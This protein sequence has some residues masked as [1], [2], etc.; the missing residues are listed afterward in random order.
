MTNSKLHAQVE[1]ALA[2][3]AALARALSALCRRGLCLLLAA[4]P[5]GLYAAEP[6]ARSE[7][8][9]GISAEAPVPEPAGGSRAMGTRS[10][11]GVMLGGY[12]TLQLAVPRGARNP[13]LSELEFE[14]GGAVRHGPGWRC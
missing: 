11:A 6:V 2:R 5:L 14:A 4:A 12:A 3:S 1:S 9:S 10:S 13:S 7:P 8:V